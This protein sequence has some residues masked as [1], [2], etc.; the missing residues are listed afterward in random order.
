MA[1]FK[2]DLV[3]VLWRTAAGSLDGASIEFEDNV[4]CC[5]V[6]CSDG[7]PGT[8]EKGCEITGINDAESSGD[9]VVFH[10]GTDCTSGDLKTSGGRVLGVNATAPDLETARILANAAC[11]KIHFKGAFYRNDIGCRLQPTRHDV[12]TSD[13]STG[14]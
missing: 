7:Y 10:A 1:R 9:I 8:Y 11:G 14:V 3:D 4:S 13:S 12:A 2:G 5:V 6:M